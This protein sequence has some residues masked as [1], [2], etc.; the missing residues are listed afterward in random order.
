AEMFSTDAIPERRLSEARTAAIG[1]RDVLAVAR[2]KHAHVHLVRARLEP[3]EPR[4]HAR[5][6]AALPRAFAVDDERALLL[7]EIA[8]RDVHRD[9]SAIAELHE[10]LALP[11]RALSRPS[12]NRALRDRAAVIGNHLVPVDR[13]R[14]SE[15]ATRLARAERRVVRKQTRPR[16]F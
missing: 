2:E 10:H 7:G 5:I 3:F 8:P 4:A 1:A 15:S 6:L 16:R 13:D 9:F 12:P 11:L 14:S